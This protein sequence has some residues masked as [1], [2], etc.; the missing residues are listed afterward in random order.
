MTTLV[1]GTGSPLAL[2]PN[3]AARIIGERIN[4]S[5]RSALRRALLERDWAYL[6][7]EAQRQVAAGAALVDV[8]VG[9]KG[10]DEAALLPEAVRAVAA[11]VDVPLSIDTRD[12]RALE[13]AL[14]VCPGRPLV[15][16]IGGER[17]VLDGI[18]L[19]IHAGEI[20]GIAGVEGNGQAELVEVIMGMREPTAG[21]V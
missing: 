14:A 9:G 16:S 10:I 5:G 11:A 6:A 19:V 4:P 15:N 2:D 17:K 18:D 21:K 7:A 3:G 13:R 1:Q 12:P 20:V 8:N